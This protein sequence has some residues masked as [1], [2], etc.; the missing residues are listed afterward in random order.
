[1]E[2]L[3][4]DVCP[5]EMGVKDSQAQEIQIDPWRITSAMVTH[6]FWINI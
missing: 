1:M 4:N 2:A 3:D 5:S 6:G